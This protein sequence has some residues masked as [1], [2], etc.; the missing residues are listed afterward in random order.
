[1]ERITYFA[2]VLLPMA[3]EGY[4]TYRVPN[5]LAGSVK[6]G[7]RVVVQFGKQKVYTGLVRRVHTHVPIGYTPK[8]ILS[9]LDPAPL[10]EESHFAFWEW[11]AAYY[12]CSTGE[13]MKAAL[14]AAFKLASET[15]IAL[16]PEFNRDYT[17]LSDKE[18]LVAEACEIQNQ[19]TLADIARIVETAKIIPLIKNLID[20][21]V[22]IPEEELHDRYQPKQTTYLS[23]HPDYKDETLL[24]Q[25]FDAL[26][27]KAPRQSDALMLFISL[28]ASQPEIARSRL[29]AAFNAGA[30]AIDALIKKGVFLATERTSSRYGE[31]YAGPIKQVILTTRQ[32]EAYHEISRLHTEK[33]VVLL[34]GVTS[35]GKTE[36]Y[37]RLIREVLDQG[38]QI[39][40]LLPEIALTGQI[41]N[42]LRRYF[43]DG[44]A[45][46]HSRHNDKERAEIWNRVSAHPLYGLRK[47]NLVVGAR[48]GLFLPFADLRLIIV[49]EEHDTSFRQANP[50]PRYNARDSAIYLGA[51]TGAKILL[52]TATP[53]IES[54]AHAKSGKYGLVQ[55]TARFGEA[56]MPLIRVADIKAG[57]GAKPM[58]SM[59]TDELLERIGEAL[60]GRSQ[61]ILFQNRRGYAPRLE[62]DKCQWV[63]SC[64]N[65][66]ISLVYHKNLN[67]LKCHYCGWSIQIP[68]AC[69]VCKHTGIQMKSFGTEKVEDEL[70]IF[71]PQARIARLDLDAIRTKN[72]HLEI[73]RR[74]EEKDIDIL[75]GTQMV[76]KGLDFENVSL[77]GILNADNMLAWPDFRAFERSYQLMAQVSGRA[78]RSKTQGSVIIQTRNPEHPAI[79]FVIKNDYEGMFN[80]QLAE[81]QRYHYP[82][83]S[84]LILIELK[85]ADPDV[86]KSAASEMGKILRNA[87]PQNVL[88]PESPLVSRIRGLFIRQILIK[89]ARPQS[90]GPGKEFIRK[91]ITAINENK[92]FRQVKIAVNVDPL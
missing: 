64:R 69:P 85:H 46:Y 87:W 66:D 42:R 53:S 15:R 11:M 17:D 68:P 74:F 73:I 75:V 24:N 67:Q 32:E 7:Y 90:L 34:H 79:Q 88:G 52:G 57:A 35:S 18:M 84:R 71:F 50:A 38:G 63:P 6:P 27:K 14:P 22:I 4:Y 70:G 2:D 29:L 28:T 19:I 40:Y 47:I 91:T 59:F 20:K 25:L 30:S 45:V 31:L 43:G 10:V 48:S 72:A 82:P 77:V 60:N 8:Y 78:G 49:D 26:E 58:K 55:L 44:V 51:L 41:I 5:D 65:C 76:T 62:C 36:I 80:Q 3:V 33:Q 54:F 92:E 37:I 83:Y 89:F 81:R 23:L 56:G 13:V 1:M 12:V 9:V 21:K 86:V 16:H 61:V 39:L